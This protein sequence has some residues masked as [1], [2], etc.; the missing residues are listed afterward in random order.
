VVEGRDGWGKRANSRF[1]EGMTERK[2]KAKRSR[3][4]EGMTARKARVS[5]SASANANTGVSPLRFASVEMTG[6]G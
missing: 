1:P 4:P 5:A 3:F 2:A 6:F